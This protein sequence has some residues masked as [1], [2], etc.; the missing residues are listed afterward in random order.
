M[1]DRPLTAGEKALWQKFIESVEP[2][3]Q[4]RV[5]R[6]ENLPVARRPRDISGPITAESFGGKPAKAVPLRD[7]KP[8]PTKH[9]LDG[10]WDRRLAKGMV[11]P[12][13]TVDLHG[14]SLS[15]A[16]GR[17]DSAL[18]LSIAAGHR[19]ILLITGK[20]RSDE[21]RRRAGG[22]GAIR[23][24]ISDWLAASRHAAHI[25]TVRRAHP[26]HGGAGALYIILRRHR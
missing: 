6:V 19:A 5:K 17:L 1:P 24:A 11:H 13:V 15:S 10:G 21:E 25:A 16:H 4:G 9:G 12:D 2:L 3:D 26:R 22:R 18:E 14:Y 8:V 20:A 23:S 7:Q